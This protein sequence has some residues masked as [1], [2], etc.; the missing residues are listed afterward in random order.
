MVHRLLAV[1]I[2]ADASYPD[3]LDKKK[4]QV[5]NSDLISPKI[6]TAHSPLTTSHEYS[7]WLIFVD[8]K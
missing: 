3:L 8:D 5:D 7:F 2:G 4:T 6:V 1:A